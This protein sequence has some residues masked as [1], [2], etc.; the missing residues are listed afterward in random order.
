MAKAKQP[1]LKPPVATVLVEPEAPKAPEAPKKQP[2]LQSGDLLPP[3]QDVPGSEDEGDYLRKYQVRKQTVPGSVGSDPPAG[4]KAEKMKV[5][6]LKQPKVRMIFP[7]PVGEAPS[8][9]QTVCLNGYR[10][11]LPKDT[12]VDV[13][14]A[15]ANVLAESL[16]QTNVAIQKGQISGDKGKEAA[17]L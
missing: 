11:E 17:L 9:K 12:Y 5:F 1:R 4:S 15:I 14:E 6:L 13:P 3:V 10:L 2:R 7:H 16:K 8:I